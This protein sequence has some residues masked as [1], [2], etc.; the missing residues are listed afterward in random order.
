LN[1]ELKQ[2]EQYRWW[3]DSARYTELTFGSIKGKFMKLFDRK[4]AS[5]EILYQQ[6]LA[7]RK[8]RTE[9]T[10]PLLFEGVDYVLVKYADN[11]ADEFDVDGFRIFTVQEWETWQNRVPMKRIH[12]GFG[13]NEACEYRNKK[14]FLECFTVTS[15]SA[16]QAKMM[17]EVFGL[18]WKRTRYYHSPLR[19]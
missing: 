18:Q 4:I 17:F 8:P 7:K 9:T 15:L 1:D 12:A 5:A 2:S 19:G 13:T 14:D 16:E 10:T 6:Y 3:K 11:Y